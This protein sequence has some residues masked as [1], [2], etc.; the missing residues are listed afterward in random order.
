MEELRARGPY[1][2][3]ISLLIL[4]FVCI[5]IYIY[6][7]MDHYKSLNKFFFSL[8]LDFIKGNKLYLKMTLRYRNEKYKVMNSFFIQIY[9]ILIKMVSG[10]GWGGWKILG[11]GIS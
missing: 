2:P 8:K 5:H 1:S 4:V 9:L 3:P 10:V 11:S 7:C 6:V